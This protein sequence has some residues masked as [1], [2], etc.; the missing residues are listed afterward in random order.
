[1]RRGYLQPKFPLSLAEGSQRLIN[2][3]IDNLPCT[4]VDEML[5]SAS[6]GIE[7]AN[8]LALAQYG[9]DAAR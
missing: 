7:E 1:M 2:F 9:R 4:C 3:H 5:V 8:T 6:A